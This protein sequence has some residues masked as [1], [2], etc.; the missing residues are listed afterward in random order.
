MLI[1]VIA[2][3]FTG[4]SDIAN[5]LA[6]G[7]VGQG[8]L[9]T[10]QYA[11]I[12]T[13]T[14]ADGIEAGVIS[15]KTRSV[16]PQL[17]VEQ[18]CAALHWLMA[19]GCRQIVFKYC[20][21]FDSTPEGNIGPVAE[22]LAAIMKVSGVVV[23]PAFPAAG[24]TVHQGHLFVDDRL[25][26]ESGM[27]N[28]PL[29]PMTDHDIRRWLGLQCANPVGLMSIAT[30]RQGATVISTA[31]GQARTDGHTLVVVDTT[32]DEDLIAIGAALADA[33]FITGGSGIATGLP[34]NFI[35]AGRATGSVPK[36]VKLSGP[37]AILVGSCSRTTL[38]QIEAHRADNPCLAISCDDL[39]NGNI[40]VDDICDFVLANIGAKPLVYSSGSPKEV[41]TAQAQHGAAAL[42]QRLEQLF[43]QTAKQ[44]I[45][46]GVKRLVVAGGE[47]SGA[48][49][50]ALNLGGLRIGP[51][52]SPG[53]PVLISD[54]Y[55]IALAL[56]SGNFGDTH[57]FARAVA[58]MG[59]DSPM[60]MTRTMTRAKP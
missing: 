43:A 8:G 59:G 1:G 60:T 16:A 42:A 41:A 27:Q 33:P 20:S 38:Q 37:N 45:E 25:L 44:L 14:A 12:P 22:A 4:A 10:C 32:T 54:A 35:R 11:G 15:L 5:T 17:A 21:T 6:K 29:S 52:I 28:H 58:S 47:T 49:T 30:V 39:M 48:V 9:R 2:D 53:V 34:A 3:D 24:R 50:Q 57:F 31:L 7:I 18:S 23:C 51:E 13:T 19:Q 55:Q 46:M 36:Q 56:K 26:S 40:A